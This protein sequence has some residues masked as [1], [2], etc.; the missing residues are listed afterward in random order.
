[1]I[2]FVQAIEGGT[3]KIGTTIRLSEQLKQLGA[4]HGP[5]KILAVMDGG[6]VEERALHEKF[7]SSWLDG[8]WFNPDQELLDFIASEGKPWDG[9]DEVPGTLSVKLRTEVV[10][11]AR[12]IIAIKGNTTLTDLISDILEPILAKME[13]EVLASRTRPSKGKGGS[14]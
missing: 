11:S 8:E 5:L 4:N 13:E 1:M 7:I 6:I 9:T 3:I 14:K 2:Y 12:V 10:K